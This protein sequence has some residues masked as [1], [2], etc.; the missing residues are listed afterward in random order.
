MLL[1]TERRPEPRLGLRSA[2]SYSLPATEPSRSTRSMPRRAMRPQSQKLESSVT[3]SC[4]RLWI[5]SC[6]TR[7]M[8]DGRQLFRLPARA[9]GQDRLDQFLGNRR[10]QRRIVI[11]EGPFSKFDRFL[12]ARQIPLTVVAQ[13][14]V[15]VERASRV[16]WQLV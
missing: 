5:R 8:P 12:I 4:W 1:G 7:S 11:L 3:G 6:S 13:A 14:E 16:G 9:G 10:G 15:I 2:S